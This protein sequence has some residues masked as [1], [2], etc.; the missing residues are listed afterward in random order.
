[1]AATIS[2]S[3]SLSRASAMA[4][5]FERFT[6][7]SCTCRYDGPHAL[8]VGGT[9]PSI[10]SLRS[11]LSLLLL[12]CTSLRAHTCAYPRVRAN[13]QE[14]AADAPRKDTGQQEAH[15]VSRA[16]AHL[17]L[18]LLRTRRLGARALGLRLLRS[19]RPGRPAMLQ[20]GTPSEV[21][22]WRERALQASGA[23]GR[24]DW[25]ERMVKVLGRRQGGD[26]SQMRNREGG[27]S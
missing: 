23:T 14:H 21:C 7:I 25:T 4:T 26:G 22:D 19:E 18:A 12:L 10:L 27:Q 6:S 5:L 24:E 2:S 8:R 9:P 1:M 15:T 3:L 11:S 20:I 17:G 13:L 16:R